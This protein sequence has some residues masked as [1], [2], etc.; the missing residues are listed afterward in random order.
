MGGKSKSSTASTQATTTTTTQEIDTTTIG[1]EDVQGSIV[2][3][4]GDITVTQTDAGAVEAGRAIG[5][6]SLDFA[7]EFG[8]VALET[9]Q[10]ATDRALD[11]GSESFDFG[12]GVSSEAFA[13]GGKAL[14]TIAQQSAATTK[15]LGGAIERAATATRSDTAAVAPE[16]FK[17]GAIVIGAIVLGVVVIFLFKK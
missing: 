16:L 10:S 3:G 4:A 7:G 13:F 8:G 15:E 1:L 2:G 5:E 14:E 9:V 17:T 11:F 6:A 12:S